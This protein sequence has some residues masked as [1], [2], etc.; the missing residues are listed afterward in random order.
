M[1]STRQAIAAYHRAVLTTPPLK[2]IVLLYDRILFHIAGAR[3]AAERKDWEV[4]FNEVM[5][6]GRIVDGLNRCLDMKAGGTVAVKLRDM[7]TSVDRALLSSVARP[8]AVEAL[9]RVSAGVVRTRD[10]WAEIA[11]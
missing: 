2:A 4:Q 5:R 10:A 6:A 9:D 11:R 1:S 3:R 8:N 7:Y